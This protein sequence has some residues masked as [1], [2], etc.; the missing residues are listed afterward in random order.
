[1]YKGIW[2]GTT[3]VA[4]KQLTASE[5]AALLNE[6]KLLKGLNH[7]NIV[8]Y[9]GVYKSPEGNMF[10]MMEFMS[11]GDVGTLLRMNKDT[12]QLVDLLSMYVAALHHITF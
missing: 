6:I 2:Q 3:E 8:R 7:P 9:F 5:S 11:Q 12:Y 10:V 4:L 1:V